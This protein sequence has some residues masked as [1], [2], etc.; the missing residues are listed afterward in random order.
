M[1]D[2]TRTT[3]INF[4]WEK[5]GLIN[6][7]IKEYTQQ[8]VDM[9]AQDRKILEVKEAKNILESY[10]YDMRDKCGDYGDRKHLCEES[11]RVDF[12]KNLNETETWLYENESTKDEYEVRVQALRTVGE[13]INLRFRFYD[14]LP[15]RKTQIEEV[16]KAAFEN[17]NAIPDDSHITAE[18]K[19]AL[20]KLTEETDAWYKQMNEKLETM[21]KWEDSGYTIAQI[22]DKQKLVVELTNKTL[23]KPKPAPKKEEKKEENKE[24]DKT[25]AP[26]ADGEKKPEEKQGDE[27][28]PDANPDATPEAP[29]PYGG[30]ALD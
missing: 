19:Q 8:E 20:L 7:T 21:N 27:P 23:N 29:Q 22:E 13:P 30:D 24:A 6:S 26:P 10:V 15:Y 9:F 28:M 18:E 5:H 14:S 11:L 4:K 3:N 25:D 16:I 12:L 2:K 17:G 1:V